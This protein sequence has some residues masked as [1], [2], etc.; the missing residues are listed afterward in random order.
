MQ[1]FG[2]TLQLNI[3]AVIP[4]QF[5][6]E[7][8]REAT[9]ETATPFLKVIQEKYPEDDDQF[10]LAV[11][12]NALRTGIR[13][14]LI[15]FMARSSVGGRVSPVQVIAEEVHAGANAVGEYIAALDAPKHEIGAK[16]IQVRVDADATPGVLVQG[17]QDERAE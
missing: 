5:L 11:L 8:R 17:L 1:T 14:D 7:A 4:K 10:M 2:L 15:A 3:T 16:A 12:K 13:L 6:E 9:A